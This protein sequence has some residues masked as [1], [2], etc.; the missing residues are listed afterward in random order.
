M[1][2]HRQYHSLLDQKLRHEFNDA[3]GFFPAYGDV[4]RLGRRVI[5]ALQQLAV[6]LETLVPSQ[7]I[8]RF[9]RTTDNEI[10][11]YFDAAV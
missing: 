6:I 8:S 10:R 2:A 11:S 5:G 3:R 4:G 7:I 1:D 9:V